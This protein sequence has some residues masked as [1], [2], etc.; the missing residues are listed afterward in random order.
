MPHP[1]ELTRRARSLRREMTEAERQLWSLLRGRRLGG[2]KFVRQVP[3]DGFIADFCCRETGLVI[4]ADGSQHAGSARDAIR[5][6]VLRRAG[7]RILRFWN[8]DILL[9]PQIVT[10]AILALLEGR[11]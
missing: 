3:I 2:Y 4:E 8:N 10:E 5:D 6:R 9:R 1:A 11:E 7:Y